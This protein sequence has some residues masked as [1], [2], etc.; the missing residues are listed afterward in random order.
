MKNIAE[1]FSLQGKNALV[2]GAE[3]IYG[4]EI[5][6]GLA[7]EGTTYV[8]VAGDCLWNIA[9]KTT[10]TGKNWTAIYEANKSIIKNPNC[11]YVGQVLNIPG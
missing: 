2:V 11:I 10:G 8:V 5:I 4:A 1:S 7:A 3:H 9:Y 6:A